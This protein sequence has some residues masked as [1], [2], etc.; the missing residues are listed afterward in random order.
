MR[1]DYLFSQQQSKKRFIT[2][3][4]MKSHKS[5]NFDVALQLKNHNLLKSGRKSSLK[6]RIK[7][8]NKW[9]N[10]TNKGTY[11]AAVPQYIV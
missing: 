8:L 7:Q 2:I 1:C 4:T 3:I 11:S 10:N 9:A 5:K 6:W